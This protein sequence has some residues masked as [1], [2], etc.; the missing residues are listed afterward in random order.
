MLFYHLSFPHKIYS[1]LKLQS[2]NVPVSVIQGLNK[3]SSS[4]KTDADFKF[5]LTDSDVWSR[6][7]TKELE[8]NI[9]T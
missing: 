9:L 7:V 1:N 4:H 3:S 8:N 5:I 2:E 6:P